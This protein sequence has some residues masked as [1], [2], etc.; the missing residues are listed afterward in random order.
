[1]NID[2][3]YDKNTSALNVFIIVSVL[4][5]I[6]LQFYY[7][8]ISLTTYKLEIFKEYKDVLE[9]IIYLLYSFLII[10]SIYIVPLP[11]LSLIKENV[12]FDLTKDYNILIE[13]LEN[14]NTMESSNKN[15][16]ELFKNGDNLHNISNDILNKLKVDN[17][18]NNIKS[19]L[20]TLLKR[21][22]QDIIARKSTKQ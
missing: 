9:R 4:I 1:M 7:E 20:T 15:I 21:P 11:N 14:N 13:S 2:S 18:Y 5:I 8:K 10:I 6:L 12:L 16:I 3:V 17:E 22:I 19:E